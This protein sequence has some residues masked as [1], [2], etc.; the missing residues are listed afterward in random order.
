MRH[1]VLVCVQTDCGEHKQSMEAA[2]EINDHTQQRHRKG[3]QAKGPTVS[4]NVIVSVLYINNK[5][6]L[7][8]FVLQ[9]QYLSRYGY[10]IRLV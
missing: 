1:N 3:V 2:V 4:N 7:H 9:S 5:V 6:N 10:F 8:W